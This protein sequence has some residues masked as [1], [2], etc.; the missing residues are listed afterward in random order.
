MNDS[1]MKKT[2]ATC[3]YRAFCKK[4][5][6]VNTVN[7]EVKC[8]EYAPDISLSSHADEEERKD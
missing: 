8:L 7:G 3:A 4:R 5:F 2:C 1:I 6:S